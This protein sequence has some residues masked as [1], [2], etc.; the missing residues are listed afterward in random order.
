MR[1]KLNKLITG[2]ISFIIH[3]RIALSKYECSETIQQIVVSFTHS[4]YGYTEILLNHFSNPQMKYGVGVNTCTPQRLS[5]LLI[6]EYKCKT[7]TVHRL[8]NKKYKKGVVGRNPTL[9]YF[10]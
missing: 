1:N 8:K 3:E 7:M 6:R 9:S 2:L 4:V 10:N 5:G